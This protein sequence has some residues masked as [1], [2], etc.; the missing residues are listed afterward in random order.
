M[1]PINKSL[2]DVKKIFEILIIFTD[3]LAFYFVLV[4]FLNFNFGVA[5]LFCI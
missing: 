3:N 1:E 4:C 5:L 2:E